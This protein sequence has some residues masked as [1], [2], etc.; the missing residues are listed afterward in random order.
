MMAMIDGGLLQETTNVGE[1]SVGDMECGGRNEMSGGKS[2][3]TQ[4]WV[5]RGM[6]FWDSDPFPHH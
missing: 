2:N 5:D 1:E 4:T 6:T 3:H